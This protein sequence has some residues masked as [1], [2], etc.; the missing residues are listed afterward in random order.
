MSVATHDHESGIDDHTVIGRALAILDVVTDATQPVA[1][2]ELSRATGIPKP[3]ALRIA[4]ALVARRMLARVGPGY[5]P[6]TRLA[7][8]A[9]RAAGG[10]TDLAA[11]PHLQELSARSRCAVAWFARFDGAEIRLAAASLDSTVPATMRPDN[12]PTARRLGDRFVF[13]M[14]GK[15]FLAEHPER[16]PSLLTRPLAPLTPM[17]QASPRRIL[18][19]L[20]RYRESGYAIEAEQVR[21]GW[22]CAV[23]R[24]TDGSGH[25]VGAVGLTAPWSAIARPSVRADLLRCGEAISAEFHTDTRA[26]IPTNR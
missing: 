13:T 9:A 22:A 1:L 14:L 26:I 7:S 25:V 20:D 21:L 16:V 17:S 19:A 8:Q 3:S 4:N 24:V 5:A 23:G 15:A 10:C 11:Q 2:A 12:W 18:E 6:G